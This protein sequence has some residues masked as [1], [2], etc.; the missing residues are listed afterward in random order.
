MPQYK[1]EDLI[2]DMLRC[3]EP[4]ETFTWYDYPLKRNR[5]IA[6]NRHIIVGLFLLAVWGLVWIAI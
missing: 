4:H 2:N 6:I 3:E 5:R 1:K